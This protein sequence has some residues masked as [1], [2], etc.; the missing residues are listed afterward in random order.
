MMDLM[1]PVLWQHMTQLG[2]TICYYAAQQKIDGIALHGKVPYMT[3]LDF[4]IK[5]RL[6]HLFESSYILSF[7]A[8]QLDN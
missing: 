1:S 8:V 6:L 2:C 5:S 4:L 3:K 7:I